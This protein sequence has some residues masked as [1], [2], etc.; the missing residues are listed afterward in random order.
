[1]SYELTSIEEGRFRLSGE[2]CIFNAEALK[3]ALLDALKTGVMRELDLSQVTEIDTSGIQLLLLAQFEAARTE[4]S[5]RFADL[6][7]PMKEAIRLLDL[8][9]IFDLSAERVRGA[10][11]AE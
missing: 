4:S 7:E 1:M 11:H 5:L 8:N 10:L 3:P 2:L 6:S 9:Y